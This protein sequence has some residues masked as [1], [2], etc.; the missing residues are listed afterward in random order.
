[1]IAALVA[2]AS[3]LGADKSAELMLTDNGKSLLSVSVDKSAP[4]ATIQAA[5][6]LAS[7]IG[8]V[9]GAEVKVI[10]ND[11]TNAPAHAIWVGVQP[12][13]EGVLPNLKLKFENPEEILI[14]CNGKDLVIAGRDRM[15]GDKQTEFG[16]ANAVYT[17]LQKYLDVRWFW[18]GPLG[19]DVI[20]KNSIK[21]PSFEYRYHPQIVLR[22]LWKGRYSGEFEEQA[23]AWFR[24]QRVTLYSFSYD[25]GHA[26]TD[27]W[28]K[29]H[30]EHPDYF[31]LQPDGS[32]DASPDAK[33]VKICVSNPKMQ[34]QWLDN[35]EKEFKADPA[36]IMDSASPNDGSMMGECV[37]PA[38]KAWDNPNGE[39]IQ[40]YGKGGA[41]KTV[42][43]TDR[44][45][46][47]WNILAK[48]LKERFPDR[49]AYVGA[50]AYGPYMSPPISGKLDKNVV[51]G[52]VG[53]F[54]FANREFRDKQKTDWKKWADNASKMVFRP[55]LFH[56]TGGWLGL[57]TLPL[58]NTI[59]DFKFLAENKCVGISVDTLP[60]CWATQGMEFYLIAQLAY[61]PLQDGNALLK[62]YYRRCF[63]N[64]S[65]EI[66]Q[67]FGIMEKVHED[68]AKKAKLSAGA[69]KE[70]I[71]ICREIYTPEVLNSAEECLK[72]AE[73]RTTGGSDMK[74]AQRVAFIRSGFDYTKLQVDI[75][76]TMAKVRESQGKDT[77]AVKKAVELCEMRKVFLSKA[78]AFAIKNA[79]WYHEARK[80]DDYMGPPSQAFRDAAG[81]K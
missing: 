14:A 6:E 22:K 73:A 19:E 46:K 62:D 33:N 39:Q 31:A 40:L 66:E 74:Y 55:N 61:D 50:M 68:I 29:Y 18:P 48:G 8:K 58:H 20:C 32:R 79:R 28:D 30:A 17:F 10:L 45:V 25:G 21:L 54:P 65:D 71:V 7:Y 2:S 3:I 70:L 11:S 60:L 37:C 49:D 75:M 47:F 5:N 9:S 64:A 35:A 44:Y 67:Y 57:P 41:Y 24:M 27:W 53:H 81:V 16:T 52:Y 76:N 38:C 63:G 36:R 56:Y 80:L 23:N 4:E 78:N 69:T 1:M 15:A 13:I 12:K 43:L 51:I 77:A 59:E 26:F 34:K 42:A 72:K